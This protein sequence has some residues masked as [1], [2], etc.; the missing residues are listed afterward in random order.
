M[1]F[2]D[3]AV[4][5]ARMTEP[6][7][8]RT[9]SSCDLQQSAHPD[10]NQGPADLQSAAVTTELCARLDIKNRSCLFMGPAQKAN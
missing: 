7:G 5:S 2:F 9:E 1:V 10:L 8:Y 4:S 6:A 3:G